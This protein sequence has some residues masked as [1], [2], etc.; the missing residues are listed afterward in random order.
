MMKRLVVVA[1][2]TRKFRGWFPEVAHCHRHVPNEGQW[3][4]LH[5]EEQ[6]TSRSSEI[7]ARHY[8]VAFV[9]RLNHRRAPMARR[10]VP[11]Q[12]EEQ[13]ESR[14]IESVAVVAAE[15]K[16]F[17][18]IHHQEYER[19]RTEWVQQISEQEQRHIRNEVDSVVMERWEQTNKQQTTVR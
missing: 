15:M 2:M 19:A 10:S 17:E 3:H 6:A 16:R 5:S 4:Y 18:T 1:A 12:R 8:F 14:R 11:G 7:A 9:D 13:A